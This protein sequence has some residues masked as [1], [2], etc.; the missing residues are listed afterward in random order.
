[1]EGYIGGGIL[2]VILGILF[3]QLCVM[4]GYPSLL[5]P[6]EVNQE[7]LL[8][9]FSIDTLNNSDTLTKSLLYPSACVLQDVYLPQSYQV[10][11]PKSISMQKIFSNF[12]RYQDK[13]LIKSILLKI[14]HIRLCSGAYS[15]RLGT[16]G[17]HLRVCC[18]AWTI[19][20]LFCIWIQKSLQKK[21]VD[22]LALF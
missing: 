13:I 10:S 11:L 19:R 15:F 3:I 21:G 18:N 8:S 22:H 9:Y 14:G 2:T 6:A 20:R 1:M 5:C 16:R 12:N 17:I 7:Y 4:Y